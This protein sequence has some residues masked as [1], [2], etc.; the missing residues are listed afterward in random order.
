MVI[1]A[2]EPVLQYFQLGN[3]VDVGILEGSQY[4]ATI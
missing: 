4:L 1:V 3:N 2:T